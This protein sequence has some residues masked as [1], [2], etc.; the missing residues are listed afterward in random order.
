[1]VQCVLFGIVVTPTEDFSCLVGYLYDSTT[2][3]QYKSIKK[4]H[5]SRTRTNF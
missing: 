2:G 5:I 3:L 4:P 1:M